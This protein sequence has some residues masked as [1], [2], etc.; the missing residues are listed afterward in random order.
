MSQP[1]LAPCIYHI[2]HV[3]NLAA[4][5]ANGGLISDAAI[6]ARGGPAATIGMATIKQRR[7]SLPVTCHSGLKVGDCVPFYFCP[8]SMML[9]VISC[10]NHPE[11]TY[12]GGQ[13]P[14]VHLEAD[15]SAVVQWANAQP[16]RWAFSLSN[17]GARYA[18]FRRSLAN[19]GD[20]D[21]DAVASTNFSNGSNTPSGLSVKEGKQAEFLLESDFPWALVQRIGVASRAVAILAQAAIENA[22]H[23]PPITVQSGWYF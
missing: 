20:L 12:R 18:P 9:F 10:A 1:P 21:W 16:R 13:G 22:A 14:I 3:N 4:I 7:L 5:V 19:L 15:L 6:V 2:T 11:L 23:K 8:R 17:A